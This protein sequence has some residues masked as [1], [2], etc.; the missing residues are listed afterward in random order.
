M[1]AI[2]AWDENNLES[3]G[4]RPEVGDNPRGFRSPAKPIF[5]TRQSIS[6]SYSFSSFNFPSSLQFPETQYQVA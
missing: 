3:L 4:L 6:S 5:I 2:F 1:I